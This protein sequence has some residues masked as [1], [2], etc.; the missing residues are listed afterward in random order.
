MKNQNSG[1]VLLDKPSG[2]T[3]RGAG[4]KIARM[5]SAKTFG[6]V[7][8]LDPM[9]SGLL[10]IALG[11]ATKM[12][13]YL[14]GTIENSLSEKEYVFSV[15]WGLETDTGDIT[16]KILNT[17]DL[18][19]TDEDIKNASN[20]LIGEYNQIPPA[21]S[22]VHING[23][24]AYELAR[25]GLIPEIPGRK[26]KIYDL[27]YDDNKFTV[28]CSP[29][30]Y[31]RSLG[32]DIAKICK[33]IGTVDMIRRTAT[34]GFNI[35]DANTLDFLENLYNNDRDLVAEYLKPIDFGLDDILVQN[36]NYE[37]A[38]LFKNGG[39]IQLLGRE[40]QSEIEC[41]RVYSDDKFIGIGFVENGCLKPKRIIK[42]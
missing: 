37:D 10:I 9:A 22:A 17:N 1:F 11:H 26:V 13:P 25:K 29:G 3:S 2:I 38:K 12:I 21:Y 18:Y 15:R 4:G 33:T 19:P 35:K 39:F 27:K 34:N 41:I 20:S 8:T 24:R 42:D 31:V 28:R 16:G 14:E 36:L 7:G 23:Q 6:H 40:Q 5:F 30:T 32:V